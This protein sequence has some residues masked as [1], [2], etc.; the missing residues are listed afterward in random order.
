MPKIFKTKFG[1]KEF[2]SL[3]NIVN[4]KNFF[5]ER[6]LE[7]RAT[8]EDI[9]EE[10][11]TL[12]LKVASGDHYYLLEKGASTCYL[13]DIRCILILKLRMKLLWLLL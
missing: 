10:N 13:S 4:N 8:K 5:I 3:D 12:E 1:L 6:Y 11:Y 2:D 7:N 9:A